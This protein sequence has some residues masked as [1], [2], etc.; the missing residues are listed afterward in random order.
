M[1]IL[2]PTALRRTSRTQQP[3]SSS[4]VCM[5][6]YRDTAGAD[7]CGR[8]ACAPCPGACQSPLVQLSFL[9]QVHSAVVEVLQAGESGTTQPS[10][11]QLQPS[12]PLLPS[13]LTLTSTEQGRKHSRFHSSASFSVLRQEKV[14]PV[15]HKVPTCSASQEGGNEEEAFAS[16]VYCYGRCQHT[17]TNNLKH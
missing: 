6:I 9:S 5:R 17:T 14:P 11:S 12:A 4:C 7:R 13:L 8:G 2:A 16:A 10:V 3:G 1:S 15:K